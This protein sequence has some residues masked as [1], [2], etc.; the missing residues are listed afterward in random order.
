MA[1]RLIYK[2]YMQLFS[3]CSSTARKWIAEDR[4]KVGNKRLTFAHIRDMYGLAG[5]DTELL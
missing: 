5:G 2:D 4:K 1:K 3:I